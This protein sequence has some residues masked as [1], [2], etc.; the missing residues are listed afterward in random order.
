MSKKLFMT[1][2]NGV[3]A[4]DEYYTTKPDATNKLGFTSYQKCFVAIRMLAYGVASELVDEY[5]RRYTTSAKW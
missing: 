3:R 5:L 4:Y 1:I 2:L